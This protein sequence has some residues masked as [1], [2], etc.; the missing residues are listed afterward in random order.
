M[1]RKTQNSNTKSKHTTKGAR[2]ERRYLCLAFVEKI[3]DSFCVLVSLAI[4]LDKAY[5]FV[6]CFS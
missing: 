4:L 6:C 3:E 2:K 1:Y 5:T